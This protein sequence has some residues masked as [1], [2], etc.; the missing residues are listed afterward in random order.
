MTEAAK[1]KVH[2]EIDERMQEL[3][4]SG[5][6][7]NEILFE[8]QSGMKLAD[9]PFFQYLKNSRTAR[10]MMLKPGEEFSADKIIEVAL[11]QDVGPDG[12]MS[13]NRQDYRLRDWTQGTGPNWEYKKKYRDTTPIIDPSA[14]FA[15]DD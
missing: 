14:Y 8:N 1:E 2:Y 11:R 12:S 6:S 5:L 4:D 7:R 10:E 15:G 9:D 3:E 13:M